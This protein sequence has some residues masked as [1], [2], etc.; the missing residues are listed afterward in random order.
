MPDQNLHLLPI[1][2]EVGDLQNRE[3]T[4]KR[5]QGRP[6]AGTCI[7][8]RPEFPDHAWSYDF[9]AERTYDGGTFRIL[10]VIDEYT[11]ECLAIRVERNLDHEDV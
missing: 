11:W 10:N 8:L 1:P 7:R 2:V 3:V 6:Q 4:H 9:T 5:F